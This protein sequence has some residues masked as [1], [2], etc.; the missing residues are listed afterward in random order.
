MT[1][2]LALA[3]CVTLLL[4]SITLVAVVFGLGEAV[5]VTSRLVRSPGRVAN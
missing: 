5:A 1:R 2:T 4:P 3:V